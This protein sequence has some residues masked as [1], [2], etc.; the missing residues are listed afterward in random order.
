MQVK[1][2]KKEFEKARKGGYAVPAFNFNDIW[3]VEGIIA[4]AEEL[5]APVILE[6]VPR[7]L[8]C[9]NRD[10]LTA[11][12]K[13]AATNAAVPV[14]LHL[15]H[16]RDIQYCKECI[17]LGF[18]MVMI[19]ASELPLKENIRAIKEVADYAHA[20]NVLVEGELGAVRNNMQ[21][22]EEGSHCLDTDDGIIQTA[23]A[24]QLVHESGVDLLAVGI[25]TAHGFYQGTPKLRF[26]R[27]SE[28]NDALGIPLV[29]HG[30]TGIPVEDIHKALTMGICKMNIGANIRF[31]YMSSLMN[32]LSYAKPTDHPL[33]VHAKARESIKKAAMEGIISQKADNRV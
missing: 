4:A 1:S 11:T 7:V 12:V 29:L 15:D 28:V 30:G 18:D 10:V 6:T 16:C 27:L 2:L 8:N 9:L 17:D 26:D 22:D 3:E 19:D 20:R 23:E 5:H 13:A 33:D 31:A 21:S 14:F 25:G 24:V 32:T